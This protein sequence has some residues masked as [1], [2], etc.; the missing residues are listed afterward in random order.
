MKTK[1]ADSVGSFHESRQKQYTE[2]HSIAYYRVGT[3]SIETLAKRDED[4]TEFV[5][6]L[7]LVKP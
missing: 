6:A 1:T 3:I 4:H 5:R 7:R 2:I